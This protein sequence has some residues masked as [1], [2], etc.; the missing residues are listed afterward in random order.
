[1]SFACVLTLCL[2]ATNT[3]VYAACGE[4]KEAVD[5]WQESV[6]QLD[7]SIDQQNDIHTSE[8][9]MAQKSI[10][11]DKNEEKNEETKTTKK[12]PEDTSKKD[13]DQGLD[14]KLNKEIAIRPLEEEAKE[15]TLMARGYYQAPYI[16]HIYWT[17]FDI[18]NGGLVGVVKYDATEHTKISLSDQKSV[19]V[20]WADSC[21]KYMKNK[22]VLGAL[23]KLL[24]K[25]NDVYEA[26][27]IPFETIMLSKVMNI[28][29]K[30][31][32]ETE[33]DF[34]KE[35]SNYFSVLFPLLDEKDQ[36]EYFKKMIEEDN[37]F[38]YSTCL[39][40][41]DTKMADYCA[42]LAYEQDRLSFFTEAV[43][44]LSKRSKASWIKKC[45]KAKEHRYL[46]VLTEEA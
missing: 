34:Y 36:Q 14:D 40:Q 21:V 2:L 18:E 26:A 24:I 42:S 16:F 41:T 46:S 17:S 38:N 35:N 28:S 9:V 43:P 15:Y 13:T 44:Y 11:S 31:L 23:K 29:N 39:A 32:E 20:Y 4:K 1:M 25:L 27:E 22:K 6:V 5:H 37:H 8:D 7:T 30:S 19:T 33:K 45:K 12:K 10:L 3:G